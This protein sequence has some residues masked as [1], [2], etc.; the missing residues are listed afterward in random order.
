MTGTLALARNLALGDGTGS[1]TPFTDQV[2]VAADATRLPIT[3]SDALATAR[4]LAPL[5]DSSNP[6]RS[7]I[8]EKSLA[9][10]PR[11]ERLHITRGSSEDLP[12]LQRVGLIPAAGCN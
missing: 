11:G 3:M 4:S 9:L 10:V 8:L 5:V 1:E 6:D 7:R 12:R 2:S